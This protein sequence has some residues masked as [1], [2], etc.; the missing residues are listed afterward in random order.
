MTSEDKPAIMQ[1]LRN[2]PEFKPIEVAVAEEVLD[3]YLQNTA[4]SGYHI[5][6]AESGSSITGYIC[7]GPTPLAKGTWDIYWIA[8]APNEQ[9]RGVGKNLLAFAEDKIRADKGRLSIIE[10]SSKPEYERTMRF[11]RSQG[12]E[13]TCRIADFYALSDDK[14]IFQK[15]LR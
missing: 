13:L 14:L 7:Y 12:Y 4:Q 10:T 3:G 9:R 6:V 1:M 8:V 11:Y 5:F 2:M 15:W